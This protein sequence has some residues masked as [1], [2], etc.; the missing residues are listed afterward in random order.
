MLMH[1]IEPFEHMEVVM[2]NLFTLLCFS[3]YIGTALHAECEACKKVV[4][5]NKTTTI[6]QTGCNAKQADIEGDICPGCKHK[7]SD[8]TVHRNPSN[9]WIDKNNQEVKLSFQQEKVTIVLEPVT[10]HEA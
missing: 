10:Q 5:Q 9:Y 2:R 4:A 6:I 7:K 1:I 8:H 3:L